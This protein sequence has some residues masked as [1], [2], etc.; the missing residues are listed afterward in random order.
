[1]NVNTGFGLVNVVTHP[2]DCNCIICETFG[3]KKETSVRRNSVRSDTGAVISKRVVR[4]RYNENFRNVLTHTEE[5]GCALCINID[6]EMYKNRSKRSTQMSTRDS[7]LFVHNKGLCGCKNCKTVT[8]F[9]KESI[10]M[11]QYKRDME[12]QIKDYEEEMRM[13]HPEAMASRTSYRT[14]DPCYYSQATVP[15]MNSFPMRHSF[16]YDNRET[17]CPSIDSLDSSEEDMIWPKNNHEY[18][19]IVVNPKTKRL[20]L[21]RDERETNKSIIIVSA[22]PITEPEGLKDPYSD[23]WQ[24]KSHRRKGRLRNKYGFARRSPDGEYERVASDFQYKNSNKQDA[25]Y[26]QLKP[27]NKRNKVGQEQPHDQERERLDNKYD[28]KRWPD[29]SRGR[30]FRKNSKRADRSE[31]KSRKHPKEHR[32]TGNGNVELEDPQTTLEEIIKDLVSGRSDESEDKTYTVTLGR[33]HNKPYTKVKII[34]CSK[35]RIESCSSILSSDTLQCTSYDREESSS[36]VY[37]SKPFPSISVSPTC[38]SNF[39]RSGGTS[40]VNL[41]HSLLTNNHCRVSEPVRQSCSQSISPSPSLLIISSIA[42]DEIAGEDR[43][44][45]GDVKLGEPT[46]AK[47]VTTPT[48]RSALNQEISIQKTRQ[49]PKKSKF[50]IKLGGKVRSFFKRNER[51]KMPPVVATVNN[52]IQ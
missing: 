13:N 26:K 24:Q 3:S 28:L 51:K 11:E 43:K 20:S 52:D 15:S 9:K 44:P 32:V 27:K 8:T 21:K 17:A 2:Y 1:M 25:P 7:V 30:K 38:S 50:K 19:E 31:Q 10:E 40:V 37:F 23:E 48:T 41:S 29:E 22:K 39:A 42:T 34:D 36:A 45:K 4:V 33:I 47:V 46:T 18:K 16:T 35:P 14:I 12:Q 6:E 5:C 49:R